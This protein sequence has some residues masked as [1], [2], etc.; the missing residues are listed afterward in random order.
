MYQKIKDHPTVRE[1]WAEEL[2]DR[3]IITAEEAEEMVEETTGKHGGDPQEAQGRG[4]GDDDL[5]TEQPRT[6]VVARSRRPPSRPR[7]SSS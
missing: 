5:E 1:L 2:E 4:L 7:S 6:P 3:G